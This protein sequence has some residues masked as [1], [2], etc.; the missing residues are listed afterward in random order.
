LCCATRQLQLSKGT[1][2]HSLF[3]LSYLVISF[4]INCTSGLILINILIVESRLIFYTFVPVRDKMHALCSLL[5]IERRLQ[6]PCEKVSHIIM[7]KMLIKLLVDAVFFIC[8]DW[9]RVV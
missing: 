4:S 1:V 8:C 3:F 5:H 6:L 2:S 9:D 7:K